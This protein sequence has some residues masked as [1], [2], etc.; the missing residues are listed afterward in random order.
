MT[1]PKSPV[2]SS[3]PFLRVAKSQG[4]WRPLLCPLPG[5]CLPLSSPSQSGGTRT[6]NQQR[7]RRE[8]RL[9][10]YPRTWASTWASTWA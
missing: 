6:V 7:R 3:L 10:P 2:F 4:L 8:G 1:R 9:P 5:L